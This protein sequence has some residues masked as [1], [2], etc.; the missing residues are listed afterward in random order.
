MRDLIG[1][2]ISMVIATLLL[3]D[4][5]LPAVELVYKIDRHRIIDEG[6]LSKKY[7]LVLIGGPAKSCDVGYSAYTAV[8]DGDSV[9]L[10]SSRIFRACWMIRF[11]NQV[12]HREYY[13]RLLFLI[14]GFGAF[15]VGSGWIKSDEDY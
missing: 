11:D 5:F 12:I 14:L 8:K 9:T 15:A 3:T 1:K 6:F 13:G 4:A 2:F 7:E 10:K